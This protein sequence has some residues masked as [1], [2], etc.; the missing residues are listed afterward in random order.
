M[1]DGYIELDDMTGGDK[2]DAE[3]LS[4]SGTPVLRE[5]TQIAGALEAEIAAVK[6]AAIANDAYGVGMRHVVSRGTIT[7]MQNA[8]V[9][10][11]SPTSD[12]S[13]LV[14]CSAYRKANIWVSLVRSASPPTKLI[15]RLKFSDDSGTTWYTAEDLL[16]EI[17]DMSVVPTSGGYRIVY[18]V[19]IL[20]PDLAMEVEGVGTTATE[21]FTVTT[22]VELK[23]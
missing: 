13:S 1:A 23:V 8:V 5:R 4:V 10:D 20:G 7:V 14:D 18:E 16:R 22:K 3:S 15:L 9:L 2:I 6:A 17:T 12:Q 19:P 21:T 11:D